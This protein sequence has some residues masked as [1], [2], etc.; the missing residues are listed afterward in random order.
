MRLF[1]LQLRIFSA[2]LLLTLTSK[3]ALAKDLDEL[4]KETLEHDFVVKGQPSLSPKELTDLLKN[5][6]VEGYIKP[7]ALSLRKRFASPNTIFVGVGRS[8][9]PIMAYLQ[10]LSKFDPH[11]NAIN[12][13]F[14]RQLKNVRFFE[15]SKE[16][17][18]LHFSRYFPLRDIEKDTLFVLVDYADTGRTLREFALALALYL[19]GRVNS[20]R[21]HLVALEK[22]IWF[23][24]GGIPHDVISFGGDIDANYDEKKFAELAGYSQFYLK[25][26]TTYIPP[27]I[28][29]ETYAALWDHLAKSI[30][31]SRSVLEGTTAKDLIY[32]HLNT[33]C[34]ISRFCDDEKSMDYFE[35][36]VKGISAG[37]LLN[38]VRTKGLKYF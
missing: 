26:G 23:E 18:H 32:K 28:E 30:G 2:L 36:P 38:R 6:D 17:I 24:S 35:F 11:I 16:Q 31:R 29:P 34:G 7:V 37:R 12:V 19:E 20:A 14:S 10:G 33:H 27:A 25:P 4:C 22:G 9:T 13:P 8:P 1:S 15:Q 21:I 3:P 5:L